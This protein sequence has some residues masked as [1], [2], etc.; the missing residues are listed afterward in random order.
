MIETLPR[1]TYVPVESGDDS[2][3]SRLIA[4]YPLDGDSS[5]LWEQIQIRVGSEN[6]PIYV[7][8]L[9]ERLVTSPQVKPNHLDLYSVAVVASTLDTLIQAHP[10]V[11]HQGPLINETQAFET[12][13]AM[14]DLCHT[15]FNES[16][17]EASR[18]T[19]LKLVNTLGT[20][21]KGLIHKSPIEDKLNDMFL[22]EKSE[23]MEESLEPI[24]RAFVANPQTPKA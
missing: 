6:N 23:A 20:F 3:M 7:R 1:S 19:M 14:V 11:D 21:H 16:A 18:I 13:S 24:R 4:R 8:P 10:A 15:R 5:W 17:T 9:V 12:M 2:I 22:A